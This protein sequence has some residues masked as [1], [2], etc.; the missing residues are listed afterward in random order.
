MGKKRKPLGASFFVSTRLRVGALGAAGLLGRHVGIGGHIAVHGLHRRI[1]KHVILA[2]YS[3]RSRDIKTQHTPLAKEAMPA[4]GLAIRE[5]RPPRQV[6]TPITIIKP[7]RNRE[8]RLSGAP[9]RAEPLMRLMA[10]RML[11][12]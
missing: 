10:R 9:L 5:N 12:W 2:R 4:T 6:S 1:Q 8:M 11:T 7:V 3:P